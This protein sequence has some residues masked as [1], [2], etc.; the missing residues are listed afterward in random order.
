MENKAVPQKIKNVTNI[1]SNT[2][3]EE[4]PQRTERLL[5]GS[6]THVHS[7]YYSRQPNS[8]SSLRFHNRWVDR[9]SGSAYNGV[10]LILKRKNILA[11]ATTWMN[12]IDILSEMSHSTNT[13]WFHFHGGVPRTNR[14][15]VQWWLPGSRGEMFKGYSLGKWK[16]SR[17]GRW[18]WL[19]NVSI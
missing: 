4:M 18:W 1:S 11:H 15:K 2:S 14:E 6:H 3:A 8:G 7:N 17:D 12:L 16:S 19:Y 5:R 13:V 9:Q 10:F